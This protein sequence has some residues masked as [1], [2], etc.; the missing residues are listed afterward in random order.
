[1]KACMR[2]N[3]SLLLEIF[4]EA[5]AEP[6]RLMCGQD[7]DVL[8]T[9]TAGNEVYGKQ[10][11]GED[12][13]FFPLSFRPLDAGLLGLDFPASCR[14]YLLEHMK[15]GARIVFKAVHGTPFFAEMPEEYWSNAG[16][17]HLKEDAITIR[18]DTTDAKPSRPSAPCACGHEHKPGGRPAHVHAPALR[19]EGRHGGNC[20]CGHTHGHAHEAPVSREHGAEH[21]HLPSR[22]PSRTDGDT[23]LA[24]DLRAKAEELN[25]LLAAAAA[26]GLEVRLTV[27][28]AD[29]ARV[30]VER[31]LR[32]L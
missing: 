28:N 27:E 18:L 26:A 5:A 30:R 8:S 16:I 19:H 2:H 3:H 22:A 23:A 11:E 17:L 15:D 20:A 6:L 9:D 29:Q 7:F 25:L 31:I 14:E 10:H 21:G 32:P 24:A 13:L 4:R 12:Y 1:M